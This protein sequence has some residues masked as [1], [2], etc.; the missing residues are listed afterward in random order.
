MYAWNVNVL[1]TKY[2]NIWIR[3]DNLLDLEAH[4]KRILKW[5][6]RKYMLPILRITTF[7]FITVMVYTVK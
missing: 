6:V 1:W 3:N 2:Q 4:E 7:I 5:I